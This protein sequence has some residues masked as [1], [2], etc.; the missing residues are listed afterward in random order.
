VKTPEVNGLTASD[1][2]MQSPMA[3]AFAAAVAFACLPVIIFFIVILCICCALIVKKCKKQ[4]PAQKNGTLQQTGAC[5]S[6]TNKTV[7]NELNYTH[8]IEQAQNV[9]SLYHEVDRKGA[10]AVQSVEGDRSADSFYYEQTDDYV[11]DD[12]PGIWIAGQ[13][14][15]T[16]VNGVRHQQYQQTVPMISNPAY[17]EYKPQP[18]LYE[19]IEQF[20][21]EENL[22]P[23]TMGLHSAEI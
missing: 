6:A 14:M 3:L 5:T 19:D 7:R 4:P 11:N 16:L 1:I 2:I 21:P 23:T 12:N 17:E 15:A 18:A 20:Q 10:Q 22:E 8:S 9:R 13:N